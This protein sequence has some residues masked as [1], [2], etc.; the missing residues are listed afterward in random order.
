VGLG[1]DC[2]CGFGGWIFSNSV[3]DKQMIILIVVS[4]FWLIVGFGIGTISII[5]YYEKRIIKD[6]FF[7]KDERKQLSGK[8]L[9]TLRKKI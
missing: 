5:E 8:S 2:P 1:F 4:L 3:V 9:R 7:T 6:N